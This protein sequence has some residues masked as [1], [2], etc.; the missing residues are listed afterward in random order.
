MYCKK[1]IIDQKIREYSI[2]VNYWKN[3]KAGHYWLLEGNTYPDKKI[4]AYENAIRRL[5]KLKNK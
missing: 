5:E 2:S 4:M 1:K 3:I